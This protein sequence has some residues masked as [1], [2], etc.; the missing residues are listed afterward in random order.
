MSQSILRPSSLLM[1]VA[2]GVLFTALRPFFVSKST[3]SISPVKLPTGSFKQIPPWKS[4]HTMPRAPNETELL[5]SSVAELQELL[6]SG[7]TTSV[8]LVTSFLDQIDKHNLNGL[9]LRAILFPVPRELALTRAKQLD[10]DRTSGQVRGP[11]HGI[12]IIVKVRL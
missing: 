9:E 3:S 2:L 1:V 12:P 7:E 8:A 6:A 5:T 4:H 10:E 11:L